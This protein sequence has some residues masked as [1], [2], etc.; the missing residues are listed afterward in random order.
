MLFWWWL[1]SCR[2]DCNSVAG[3]LFLF[4]LLI[5]FR[6]CASVMA[7]V[8]AL[9]QRLGVICISVILI[10]ISLYQKKNGETVSHGWGFVKWPL[11]KDNFRIKDVIVSTHS[12]SYYRR[13]I[14]QGRRRDTT[15]SVRG[16][17]RRCSSV[18]GCVR[19]QRGRHVALL[20]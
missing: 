1:Y 6:M 19:G 11:E 18:R 9:L 12:W 15:L 7:L 13:A 8:I 4:L 20:R 14:R 5:V 2:K 16:W 10:Y 17:W 3:L